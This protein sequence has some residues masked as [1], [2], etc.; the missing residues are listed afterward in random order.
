MMTA[1]LC[2]CGGKYPELT[3]DDEQ[4]ILKYAAT[5]LYENDQN[6]DSRLMTED[7]MILAMQRRAAHAYMPEPEPTKAPE[8]DSDGEHAD[9]RPGDDLIGG[10]EVVE[11]RTLA[12]FFGLPGIDISYQG[13][14]FTKSYPEDAGDEFYFAMDALYG[15]EL[16][17]L[18]YTI[19][20]Q[21]AQAAQ[22]DIL[23]LKP[24]FRA[25]INDGSQINAL[26][27]LLLDDMK[28][29][30][31]TLEP[32]ESRAVVVVFEVT[33]AEAASMQ[34]LRLTVKTEEDSW[35]VEL[36]GSGEPVSYNGE[37]GYQTAEN[38]DQGMPVV[39]Y[40]LPEEFIEQ[41]DGMY[42]APDYPNDTANII[43]VSSED[44][45]ESFYYS[46]KSYCEM[47]E[48]VY[49]QLYGYEVTVSCSEF[50][51]SELNGCRTLLIRLSY[52]LLDVELE[53]VAFVVETGENRTT[54]I[55]YTQVVG[56]PWTDAFN[57]SLDSIRIETR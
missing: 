1:A 7:E 28:T 45:Q 19:T 29:T 46:E 17:I 9:G 57:A 13:Y 23:N 56:G 21:N 32:G 34:Q 55:T 27:T 24:R 26:T 12:E 5:L 14:F 47:L 38:L 31:C 51:K 33:E 42:F 3:D 10:G 39:Y 41:A 25:F 44:D 18:Q 20:N 36:L 35:T 50:T 37:E 11:T 16:L 43:V 53:Q 30:N 40:E 2:G 15:N 4:A 48:D 49:E 22:V 52:N 54:G 6:R 8:Q